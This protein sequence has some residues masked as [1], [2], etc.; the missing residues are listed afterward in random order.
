[1]APEILRTAAKLLE[2]LM[3]DGEYGTCHGCGVDRVFTIRRHK[4]D[5]EIVLTIENLKR[6]ADQEPADAG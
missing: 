3:V 6:L 4:D 1:M 2:E 5:C